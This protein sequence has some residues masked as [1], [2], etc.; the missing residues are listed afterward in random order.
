MKSNLIF[1]SLSKVLTGGGGERGFRKQIQYLNFLTPSIFTPERNGYPL[2]SANRES[3]GLAAQSTL[4][5]SKPRMSMPH[6]KF[7]IVGLWRTDYSVLLRSRCSCIVGS[8]RPHLHCTSQIIL[9]HSL[10]LF[11]LRILWGFF[12]ITCQH[13]SHNSDRVCLAL[14]CVQAITHFF[15][16]PPHKVLRWDHLIVCLLTSMA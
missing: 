2:L 16:F 11:L 8:Q 15:P 6:K 3:L 5:V 12:T 1:Y 14:V 13:D 10:F 9:V 4:Q 7:S